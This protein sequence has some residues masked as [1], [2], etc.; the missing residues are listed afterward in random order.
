MYEK[1]EGKL[2]KS[3]LLPALFVPMTGDAEKERKVK[4]DPRRPEIHNGDFE[5][6]EV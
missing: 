4:P 1:R 2:E 6:A 3:S 5:V